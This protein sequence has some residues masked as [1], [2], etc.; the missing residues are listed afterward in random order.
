MICSSMS[1][2]HKAGIKDVSITL[3]DDCRHEILNDDCKE[4]VEQDV[5]DFISENLQ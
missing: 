3:Y 5:L 4:Q 2:F 1:K